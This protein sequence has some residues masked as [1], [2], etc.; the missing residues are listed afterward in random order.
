MLALYRSG[1]QAEALE[2][3]RETRRVL[4]EEVGIEPS[5][6]LQRLHSAVLGQDASLELLASGGEL[7]GELDAGTA[8]RSSVG[9]PN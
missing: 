9:V 6:E 8:R 7:P 2:V 4:V 3:Y 1:R 5:V